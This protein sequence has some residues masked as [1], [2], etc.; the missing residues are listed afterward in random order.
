VTGILQS[1]VHPGE[2]TTNYS[3]NVSADF[4]MRFVQP[5][6]SEDRR[7]YVAKCSIKRSMQPPPFQITGEQDLRQPRHD[8]CL[9]IQTPNKSGDG[10]RWFHFS[11]RNAIRYE[12]PHRMAVLWTAGHE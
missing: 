3:H 12:N 11:I 2:N 5:D 10:L 4:Y 6:A 9:S 1:E 8:I 7:N